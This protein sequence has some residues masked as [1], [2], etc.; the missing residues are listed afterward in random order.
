M[1]YSGIP[2]ILS[3]ISLSTCMVPPHYIRGGTP[4]LLELIK[5]L[6]FISTWYQ[7]PR[8]LCGRGGAAAALSLH[9]SSSPSAPT[10][11]IVLAGRPRGGT[12]V[13]GC[14]S[15]VGGCYSTVSGCYSGLHYQ[16][17]RRPS[18][19]WRRPSPAAAAPACTA[20][21]AAGH[22]PRG[23]ALRRPISSRR[24]SQPAGLLSAAPSS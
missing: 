13:G 17:R 19:L 5:T 9:S 4:L 6:E 3:T 8:F 24:H 23:G 2:V 15:T 22:P 1:P 10:S 16:L 11:P 7:S 18:S 12:Y 21:S 14:Y 20:R